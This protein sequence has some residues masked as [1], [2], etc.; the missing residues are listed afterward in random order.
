MLL[1]QI[2][3]GLELYQLDLRVAL[4]TPLIEVVTRSSI[5]RNLEMLLVR[6]IVTGKVK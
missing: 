3:Y 5:S 2:R 4:S 1:P 6:S